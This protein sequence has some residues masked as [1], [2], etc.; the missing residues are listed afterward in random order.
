MKVTNR[1]SLMAK[2]SE[3]SAYLTTLYAEIELY[4][5][6][7]TNEEH[8]NAVEIPVIPLSTNS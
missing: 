4:T 5:N 3:I 8:K 1:I 7:N 2:D 6:K